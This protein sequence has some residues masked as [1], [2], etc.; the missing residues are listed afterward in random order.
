MSGGVL[1]LC[2]IGPQ[3]EELRHR[4]P[5]QGRS[6]LRA[7]T[8]RP[9]LRSFRAGDP[10]LGASDIRSRSP[11]PLLS[12]VI[13]ATSALPGKR[14]DLLTRCIRSL[15]KRNFYPN[16]EYVVV[17]DGNLTDRQLRELRANPRI[18]LA[19]NDAAAANISHA[20]NL[21]VAHAHGEFICLLD[22][23]VDVITARGGEELVSYLAVN[24]EVGAMG[25]LCLNKNGTILQNGIVL[26]ARGPASAGSG[27]WRDFGGHQG[28]F[29][30]RRA[31]L[32][33]GSAAM[34]VKKSV[35]EAVGGFSDV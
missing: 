23:G 3:P 15:E 30:C 19:R 17:H 20:L 25:P 32:G 34:F 18:I 8:R 10:A 14:G 21:G 33:V 35:Y 2:R 4:A 31:V 29:R 16:S 12:Y 28:I 9:T 1:R 22:D 7:P 11:P 26:L 24:G 27:Q 13:A 6:R 5:T